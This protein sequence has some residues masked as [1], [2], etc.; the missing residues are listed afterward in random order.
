MGLNEAIVKLSDER[1]GI[2]YRLVLDMLSAQESE[3]CD[4]DFDY[5]SPEDI[6]SIK[7]AGEERERGDY[8][9]FDS[10]EEMAAF[11]GVT[12]D[13]A[14]A[15]NKKTKPRRENF[16]PPGLCFSFFIFHS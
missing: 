15:K 14:P 4:E 13:Y 12:L 9:S 7:R 6:T 11:F 8:V 16:P 5:L 3:D 2:V 10:A 1:R